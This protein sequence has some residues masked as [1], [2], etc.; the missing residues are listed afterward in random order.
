[1]SRIGKRPIQVPDGVEVAVAGGCVTVHGPRGS[2][3]REISSGI[4]VEVDKEKKEVRCAPVSN[5]RSLWAMWGLSRV[6]VANMVTGVSEG[7]TKVLEVIGVG[8]RAE[9][10]GMD[11]MVSTGYSHPVLVHPREGVKL[12][13]D[14]PTK[15]VVSGIDKEAVGQ[16]AAEIRSIRSPEP[17]KGKGI[18]YENEHI[19]RKAGKAGAK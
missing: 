2:L 19:I 5:S 1:M 14:G 16:S 10:K 6:L 18:R 11:L 17:Y 7:F 12:A 4:K 8:Y 3:S 15:V 13:V 9:M